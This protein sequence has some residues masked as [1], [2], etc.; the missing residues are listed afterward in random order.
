M[1]V[2][3]YNFVVNLTG[4]YFHQNNGFLLRQGSVKLKRKSNIE[5][6][7]ILRYFIICQS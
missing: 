2:R 4:S 5:R 7:I 3:L 1:G 6:S